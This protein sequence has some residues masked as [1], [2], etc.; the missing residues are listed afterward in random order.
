MPKQMTGR[1]GCPLLVS[2]TVTKYTPYELLGKI[3]NIP[4]KLQHVPQPLYNF[5]DII[6]EI[7]RKM[8]N[9]QQLAKER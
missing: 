1:N 6:L 9:C 4:G 5:D 8:Q 3:A 7:K 2:H